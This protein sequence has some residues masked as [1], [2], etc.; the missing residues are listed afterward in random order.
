VAS[1]SVVHD[2]QRAVKEKFNLFAFEPRGRDALELGA[3]SNV[4]TDE[5]TCRRAER[6]DDM[7]KVEIQ[8]DVIKKATIEVLTMLRWLKV[9]ERGD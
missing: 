3:I 8:Q 2:T 6:G 5:Y 4:E 9:G 1:I 7:S